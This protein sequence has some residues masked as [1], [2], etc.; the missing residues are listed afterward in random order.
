MNGVAVNI[1]EKYQ[2]YR[3]IVTQNQ[4]EYMRLKSSILK[5]INQKQ[6]VSMMND[7]KWF[8]LLQAVESLDFP[9]AFLCKTL[10]KNVDHVSEIKFRQQ[11][12]C[13]LGNWQ[14]FYC[15][16][17]PIFMTIEYI[18]VKPLLRKHQGKLVDDLIYDQCD[19][20]RALLKTL[21]LEYSEMDACF[22]ICAYQKY[23]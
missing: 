23:A 7:S 21:N 11:I 12:P 18:L 13:Y 9:P 6:F 1:S 20:F 17:M 8:Q 14:P 2:E 22:K 10:T 3:K 16:A 4:N 15:E 5:I 19:E